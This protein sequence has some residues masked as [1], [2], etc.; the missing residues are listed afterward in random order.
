MKRSVLGPVGGGGWDLVAV[1]GG[2]ESVLEPSGAVLDCQASCQAIQEEPRDVVEVRAE[3]K[4][5]PVKG[6]LPC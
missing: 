1:F 4:P 3:L 6:P 5:G 2:P